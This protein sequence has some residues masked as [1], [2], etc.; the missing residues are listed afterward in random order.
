MLQVLEIIQI[1]GEEY[2]IKNKIIFVDSSDGEVFRPST[3]KTGLIGI[4][5][6]YDKLKFDAIF[7][8]GSKEYIDWFINIA[9]KRFEIKNKN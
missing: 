4:S 2:G 1:L 5:D 6:K 7:Q 9:N 8:N 3:N